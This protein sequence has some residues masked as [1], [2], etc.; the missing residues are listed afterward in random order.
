MRRLHYATQYGKRGVAAQLARKAEV[1]ALAAHAAS[2]SFR[3]QERWATLG[4]FTARAGLF[5]EIG[6]AALRMEKVE[7]QASYV[8]HAWTQHGP[9]D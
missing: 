7:L 4:A 2:G 3:N 8:R 1:L 6:E 5:A 9:D